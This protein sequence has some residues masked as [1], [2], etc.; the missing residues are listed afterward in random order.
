VTRA[1]SVEAIA[2]RILG[3]RYK[4]SSAIGDIVVI[5]G[6]TGPTWDEGSTVREAADRFKKLAPEIL[7]FSDVAIFMYDQYA[8]F[9][10]VRG[11]TNAA[12]AISFRVEREQAQGVN[13]SNVNPRNFGKLFDV[14]TH[15]SLRKAW[16]DYEAGR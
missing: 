5:R 2:R 9:T 16:T 12:H 10:D 13:W 15:P 3:N 4:E 7:A 6:N 11:N 8:D 1:Q 14:D